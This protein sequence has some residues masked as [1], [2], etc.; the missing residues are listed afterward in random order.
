MVSTRDFALLLVEHARAVESGR[1]LSARDVAEAVK[2]ITSL[3]RTAGG[4]YGH[5]GTLPDFGLNIAI[6]RFL[7]RQG[8]RL[9]PLESFIDQSRSRGLTRSRILD[10]AVI[11]ESLLAYDQGLVSSPPGQASIDMTEEEAG[12]MKLLRARIKT[13]FKKFDQASRDKAVAV[14]E[15]TIAGNPD[16]QMSLM[17]FYVRQA[18]GRRGST[19]KPQDIAALGVANIFFWT[20]F[21]IYDD[22]WDEDEAADPE[23]LPIANLLARDYVD[24]FGHLL[25]AKTDFRVF[26]HTMMDRL[27]AANTWE[28][29]TCRAS[30]A[31]GVFEVPDT[32]PDY[33]DFDIKFYPACGHVLGPVAMLVR[34]GY[35]VDSME[36]RSLVNYF[37]HYLVAMQLNDDAHDWKED[38]A[39]GHIST[40]VSLLLQEWIKAHPGRRAIHLRDDMPELEQLFWFKVLEPICGQVL[41]RTAR[42]RRALRRLTF[43]ENI[44]SL[45][46]LVAMH[47]HSAQEALA[48]VDQ[49]HELIRVFK[50]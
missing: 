6:A 12:Y 16:K 33:G 13:R 4:P 11:T 21:I 39:R 36:V 28:M 27:D 34:L 19:F 38:L 24:Y 14:I 40:T 48:H 29:R 23:L 20:A 5:E 1:S 26:F 30:V 22:F 35:A 9:A 46:R 41:L 47:E 50:G 10:D 8:V 43:L 44:V 37:R 25:P 3:E 49:G 32:L 2:D 18:L 42:A 17:S 45:E 7:V 15:R 31:E